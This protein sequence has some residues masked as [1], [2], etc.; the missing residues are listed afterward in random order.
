V[1]NVGIENAM[2][3]GGSG[4]GGLVGWNEG[5]VT[6]SYSTG[7]VFGGKEVGGLVGWNYGT[8]SN[9]FAMGSVTGS[10][11]GSRIGG[12]IGYLENGSVTN[13]YSTGLVG[14][15]GSNKGG[16]IGSIETS[17]N[18]TVTSSYWDVETSGMTTSAGGEGKTTAQM[19]QQ[20]TFIDWDFTNIWDI[21]NGS[22][23]SWL[24]C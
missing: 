11:A 15:S 8:V 17:N 13:T 22:T 20:S 2:V 9:S 6:K 16:L 21:N 24:R 1:K 5:T 4:V 19:K 23:Y 18:P 10:G 14:G 7:S 12:L 3:S